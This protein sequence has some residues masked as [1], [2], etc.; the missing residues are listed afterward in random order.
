MLFVPVDCIDIV[1]VGILKL[2]FKS[3][4]WGLKK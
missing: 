3:D 1:L 4:I 2:C